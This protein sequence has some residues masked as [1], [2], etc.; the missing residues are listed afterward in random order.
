MTDFTVQRK[1]VNQ[2]TQRGQRMLETSVQRDGWIDAQTAAANGEMISGSARLELAA[3]KFAGVEP[4]VIESDGTRPVIVKRTDILLDDPA[5]KPRRKKTDG[6]DFLICAC[7][8]CRV[9]SQHPFYAGDMVVYDQCP[10]CGKF[11]GFERPQA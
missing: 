3:D 4:I 7:P 1:N 2:H 9:D 8:E 10:G 5:P 6:P 11:V